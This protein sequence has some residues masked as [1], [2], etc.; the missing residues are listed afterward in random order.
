MVPYPSIGTGSLGARDKSPIGEP[1]GGGPTPVPSL[2]LPVRN[3]TVE[4]D[5]LV[6]EGSLTVIVLRKTSRPLSMTL[7]SEANFLGCP[8]G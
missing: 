5:S 8:L 1:S 6:P 7:K 2:P 3:S 4:P